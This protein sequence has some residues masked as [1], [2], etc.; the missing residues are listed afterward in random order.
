MGKALAIVRV[1]VFKE[2]EYP[3]SM[4]HKTFFKEDATKKAQEDMQIV[5]NEIVNN[6]HAA[7]D[8]SMFKF[9][10]IEEV[11]YK[12]R[13][14]QLPEVDGDK[15]TIYKAA[16]VL[17]TNKMETKYGPLNHEL[18]PALYEHEPEVRD[19]RNNVIREETWYM[20]R[21]IEAE[22]YNEHDQFVQLLRTAK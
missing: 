20:R 10:A 6:D 1:R 17:T 12:F 15:V 18:N 2:F 7:I 4:L 8:V 11:G 5:V 19:A 21:D 3:K 13:N 16:K 14:R 9:E 22:F